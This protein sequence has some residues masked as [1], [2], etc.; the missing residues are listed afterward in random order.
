MCGFVGY[1]TTEPFSTHASQ[2]VLSRMLDQ[3]VQRGPDDQGI[4]IDENE[5]VALGHRR[6]AIID[7]SPQGHQ[8]MHSFCSR[9]V[10]AFNGEIY[11]FQDIRQTID[12]QYGSQNW[13]GHSDT[14]VMLSA[15]SF[16]GLEK[17]LASFNGMFAFA[18]WDRIEKTLTL[19]RDRLGE[20][21]LYYGWS[22]NT[23]LFGSSLHA[24]RQHPQWQ[25][26]IHKDAFALY[27]QHGYVPAPHSI[28]E[29]IY[30]LMPGAVAVVSLQQSKSIQT[31]Y[32]W[33]PRE[34]VSQARQNQFAGSPE[35]IFDDFESRLTEA[36]RMR[37]ISD[38]PLGAFL[39]GGV[40]SS[41]I[42][43]IMQTISS[44]PVKT[45]SIG[46]EEKSFDEAVYAKEVAKHLATD[47]TEFYVTSE[48]AKAVIPSLPRIYDEPFSDISQIPTLLVSKMA[49]EHVTVCLSGDGGDEMF[50]GYERYNRAISAW[51]AMRDIPLSIR[52]ALGGLSQAVPVWA[53][54]TLL[55][56]NRSKDPHD[57]L[58]GDRIHKLAELFCSSDMKDVYNA[59]V[60]N[61][62]GQCIARLG[63]RNDL[64]Y[65]DRQWDIGLEGT[66]RMM[67]LDMVHYL[68]GD[69]L[70][71]VD[72]ASMA[73]SLE[74]R[75][76]LL[77]HNLVEWAWQ[78]PVQFRRQYGKNKW[79]LRHVLYKHVPSELIERPKRGFSVPI[80]S[81]LRN[82]LRH[83]AE[84]LLQKDRL[85]QHGYMNTEEVH[86]L[87]QEH[88]SEKRNWAPTLWSVLIFQA[89]L[90]EIQ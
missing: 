88:L 69:I 21:P 11:N 31:E 24:L 23:F 15:I 40:D 25:G 34:R 13:K 32:F 1:I 84:N 62:R 52:K 66:S 12:Q 64:P 36:V 87:W 76:P 27:I 72:R 44:Q 26:E 35:A 90:E 4:W 73:N 65:Y 63:D 42:V 7:L 46:F 89:W 60:S 71:K 54:D 38:V 3:I 20:K 70:T 79:P 58:T 16:M 85:E 61:F 14:E 6:L 78:L 49:R 18:L 43:S 19:A 45:F 83:W 57:R 56:M 81:W 9:Y 29:N 10:I 33:D 53:W 37:M 39:S 41:T 68:P 55:F 50:G 28:F 5:G 80:A 8:P 74:A 59:L 77:D 2:E 82:D 17:A 47:H 51:G 75:V 67:F 48:D 30:K 86:K 22:G